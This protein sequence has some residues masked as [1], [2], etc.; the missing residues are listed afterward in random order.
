MSEYDKIIR[1]QVDKGTI[2]QV[3]AMDS[4]EILTSTKK[5]DWNR[6]ASLDNPADLGS[7]G[8]NALYLKESELWWKGPVWL[9]K[10]QSNWPKD[11]KIVESSEVSEERKQTAI[12]TTASEVEENYSNSRQ[13]GRSSSCSR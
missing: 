2:E 4:N 13:E 9:R 3:T 5:Q 12:A 7:R 11:F 6:V 8:V 10:G 1:E